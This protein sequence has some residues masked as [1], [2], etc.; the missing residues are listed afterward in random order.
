MSERYTLKLT[1]NQMDAI[2]SAIN[3]FR[4]SYDGVSEEEMK[5]WGINPIMNSL[6]QVEAKMDKSEPKGKK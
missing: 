2:Y 4:G 3:I 5:D 6:R 1:A